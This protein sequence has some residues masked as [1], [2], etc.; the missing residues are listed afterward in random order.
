MIFFFSISIY[1]DNAKL[2]STC[3]I[4][5]TVL[6]QQKALQPGGPAV[7]LWFLFHYMQF[8]GE[9][10]VQ[11]RQKKEKKTTFF[12]SEDTGFHITSTDVDYKM[13]SIHSGY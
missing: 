10:L 11:K 9:A 7:K 5:D 13:I 12:F 1:L 3:R 6:L 2:N 8:T 4:A